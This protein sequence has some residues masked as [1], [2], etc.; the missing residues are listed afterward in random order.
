MLKDVEGPHKKAR[1][2]RGSLSGEAAVPQCLLR[3]ETDIS[4]I[5]KV[6]SLEM[7]PPEN[8]AQALE[9]VIMP[10]SVVRRSRMQPESP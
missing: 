3:N 10:L 5:Q 2:C 9:R 6:H 7:T 1:Q 8:S 4:R